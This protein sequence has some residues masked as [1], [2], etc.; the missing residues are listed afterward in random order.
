MR[1]RIRFGS[2]AALLLGIAVGIG[3]AARAKADAVSDFYAG[4]QMIVIVGAAVGG[5]YDAQGRLMARYLGKFI[6]GHPSLVVENMPAGGSIAAANHLFNI[7]AKDGTTIGLMQRNVLTAGLTSPSVVH[8]DIGKFNWIGSL[9]N[10]TGLLATWHTAPVVTA[11]DLFK[12]EIIVGATIGTDTEITAR[13][14]NERTGTKMKIVS[15]YKGNAAVL[16]AMERGEVQGIADESWSNLKTTKPGY[17]K[18]HL[19]RLLM[20]NALQKAPDVPG[21]PPL[22]LDFARN[23]KDREVM[24]LYFGQK[25]VARPVLAPPGVPA[26]R[27]KALRAAFDAMG[28]SP[29]FRDAAVT[30]KLELNPTSY[31]AVEK[32]IG[33]I[34]A[35][36]PDIAKRFAEATAPR[37]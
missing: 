25:V 34:A 35:T 29:E 2:A 9:A 37:K 6:P 15:G 12:K 20:Q 33:R 10:E 28:K 21:N 18:G 27:L 11:A 13:L 1:T 4:K 7:A 36:P 26:D 32:V 5:G 19:I 16:L 24:E 23:P 22:S 30:S 3:P 14:L 8:F 17:L 31:E